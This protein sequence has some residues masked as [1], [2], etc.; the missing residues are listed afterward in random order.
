MSNKD[1]YVICDPYETT[2]YYKEGYEVLSVFSEQFTNQETV[3]GIF[4]GNSISLNIPI[5]RS[6]PKVLMQL[7]KQ[8][9][10]LYGEKRE[11]TT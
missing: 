7:T 6:Y 2:R 10:V 9:E 3:H 4:M 8:A 11:N 1:K 5:N